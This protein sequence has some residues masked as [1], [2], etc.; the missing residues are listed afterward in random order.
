MHERLRI[1]VLLA[2]LAGLLAWFV[3]GEAR[4]ASEDL[5]AALEREARSARENTRIVQERERW[6]HL[7]RVSERLAGRP[8]APASAAEVR[9]FLVRAAERHGVAL[10]QSRLQPVVRPPQGSRGAEAGI[11]LLGDPVSLSRFLAAVEGAGWPLRTERATLAIRGGLGTL[12]ATVVFLW[13]DPAA[14]FTAAEADRLADDP[15]MERLTAWLESV[16]GPQPATS[17][18]AN[19]TDGVP[20]APPVDRAADAL[21]EP[22]GEP[23]PLPASRSET[24]QLHGFVNVGSGTPV[25]AALFYRGE[26]RLVTVGDRVGEYTVVTLEP[27]E[28][29]VLSRE[30]APP[31]RLVLR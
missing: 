22:P 25:Q 5:T 31:L 11:T 1:R 21:L 3:W 14:S 12:T 9:A 2:L 27:S 29:V 6:S 24:P 15:R 26:T 23:A 4:R 17:P 10:S 8:P 30:E 16:A 28:A 7:R 19:E 18:A 20:S 13:P